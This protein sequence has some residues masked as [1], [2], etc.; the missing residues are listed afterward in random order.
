M[1]IGRLLL[2]V[3]VVVVLVV[4]GHD[5]YKITNA[6]KN[7]RNVAH[8]AADTAASTIAKTHNPGQGAS[9]ATKVVAGSGDVVISY[10]YDATNDT[11]LIK[12]GGTASAWVAGKIDPSWTNALTAS[13]SAHP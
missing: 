13:A 12:V 11:V 10:A 2:T 6:A 8:S 1:R 7:L 9:A 5:G 3:I 4:A